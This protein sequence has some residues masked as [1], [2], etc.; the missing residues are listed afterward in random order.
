P[1]VDYHMHTPLC[2]HAVG[3]PGEYVEQAIKVGLSEIGFSDHAPLVSHEDPRYTMSAAQLPRYHAM[4][5]KVQKSYKKFS[6]KLGLEADFV[7]GFEDKTRAILSGYPYDFVIGSIHFIDAWA[8]DDPDPAQKVKW[9]EKDIDQVYRDYYKL[10]R[11]SALSGFYDIMGHV[12]LVKKFGYRPLG[13]M[14]KDIRETAKVFKETGV[15]IEINTSGLR[16]PVKEI[17]PSLGALKIYREE[18]VPVTFSSDSHD[19]KDVGRDYDKAAV[20]AKEAGYTE[21]LVFKKRKIE[22]VEKL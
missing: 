11:L 7:P 10:L 21:Y 13:D 3:E 4:I 16:K 8:F 9:K 15:A 22:R 5:E 17:Y 19:P 6:I 14:T 12:D 2:G 20:L 1:K 18:G